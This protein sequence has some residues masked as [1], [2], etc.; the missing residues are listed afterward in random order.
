MANR[1]LA[2]LSIFAVDP[3]N[4]DADLQVSAT[5]PSSP[6]YT[7]TTAGPDHIQPPISF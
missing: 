2:S 7:A 5:L 6:F 3:I 1:A 4:A